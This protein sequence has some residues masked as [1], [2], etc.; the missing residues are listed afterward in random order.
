MEFA[1]FGLLLLLLD[2]AA[3]RW[4]VDSRE[5]IESAEWEHRRASCCTADSY[6]G[7]MNVEMRKEE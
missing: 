2:L 6:P 1:L 7:Q 5:E 3:L 4:G